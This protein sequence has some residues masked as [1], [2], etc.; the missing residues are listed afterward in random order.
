MRIVIPADVDQELDRHLRQRGE[1]LAFFGTVQVGAVLRAVDLL[2]AGPELLD[3]ADAWHVALTDAGRQA[4][5]RWAAE[6]G[7]GLAEV[8]THPGWWPAEFSEVDLGGL[9]H[10]ASN[11]VWRLGGRPYAALVIASASIDGLVWRDRDAVPVVPDGVERSGRLLLPTGR[12][13]LRFAGEAGP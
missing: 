13:V 2:T 7:V 8:H 11:V 5:L 3:D 6:R 12:S 9:R 1:Q 4:V 10:W